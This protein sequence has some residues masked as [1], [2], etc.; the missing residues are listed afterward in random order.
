MKDYYI[1]VEMKWDSYLEAKNKKEAIALCKETFKE[2]F[3][4]ELHDDEIKLVEEQ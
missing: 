4:V 1:S 2:E 3:N